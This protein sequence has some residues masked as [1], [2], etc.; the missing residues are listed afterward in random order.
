MGTGWVAL[1]KS[2]GKG[3]SVGS[4]PALGV[5]AV[6]SGGSGASSTLG[7]VV[8]SN[9][10]LAVFEAAEEDEDSPRGY[11]ALLVVSGGRGSS[12][13]SILI[14]GVSGSAGGFDAL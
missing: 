9:D 7:G 10:L 8:D 12:S 2:G 6:K 1:A 14:L 13:S 5:A 4:L 3:A 11:A